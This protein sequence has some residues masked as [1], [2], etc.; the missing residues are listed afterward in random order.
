DPAAAAAA[1]NVVAEDP[2][3]GK[4]QPQKPVKDN[5]PKAP[6]TY[7][8]AN[9]AQVD[10][11]GVA[12]KSILKVVIQVDLEKK[13]IKLIND[14]RHENGDK[15]PISGR[16]TNKKLLDLYTAL[17]KFKFKT[18]HI[19]E[20]MKSSVLYGG[21]LHSALDWL[22]LNLKDEELP[23]GFRQQM[24]EES[25]RSRPKFQPIAPEKPA[26]APLPKPQSPKEA[27]KDEAAT[28]KDWILRYAEQSS[29]EEEEEKQEEE[30]KAGGNKIDNIIESEGKFD[31]NDRYLALTAQL[32]DTREMAATAKL[33]RDKASQRM[34]QDRIRIIQ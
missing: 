19:E 28:M 31:P 33:K 2:A 20:A 24:Q 26:A 10:T 25:Q 17:Q 16:L 9:T 23:E 12:D 11:G 1:G 22:C 21:D 34:A 13:I 8:L 4:K 32:Y 30:G 15:G 18:E 14:F 7:S 5:K 6:R 29:D 3:V 27:P